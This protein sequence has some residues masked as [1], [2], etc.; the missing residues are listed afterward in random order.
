MYPNSL[1]LYL[2]LLILC[3]CADE[4]TSS[5]QDLSQDSSQ[6]S[7]RDDIDITNTPFTRLDPSCAAFTGNYV[8][9][10]QDQGRNQ[11]F[12]GTLSITQE[13]DQCIFVSNSIPHHDFNQ[14]GAFATPVQEVQ[15][16]FTLPLNPTQ[17]DEP[18]PLTLE[19]DNA[20]F[21]NGVKLDQI[22]AAC[23]GIGNDPLGREKIG[24]MMSATPWRYDPMSSNNN[25]G[26]DDYYAHTQ[27]DGAYHYHGGPI[28]LYDPSGNQASGVVGFA[29]D[30]F[31]IYGPYID[32]NGTIRKVISGYRLKSGNRTNLSGEG[33]F[34]GGMWD[35]TFIDDYEFVNSGDLDEC[36]GR[37]VNGQYQY[38]ITD[39]YPWVIGCFKGTPDSS[40]NKRMQR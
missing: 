29:A 37:M 1:I 21:L 17:A 27:P 33:A 31:P 3:G 13:E 36:N 4:S 30:G 19:Y 32:E 5:S 2:A 38:H 28:A 25:F 10:V 34:P 9:Y 18:T 7:S 12:T 11:A 22:A 6:D 26:T 8:S 40:F 14:Q 23:Y 20:I 16:R 39:D 24:C 15:E 35:G